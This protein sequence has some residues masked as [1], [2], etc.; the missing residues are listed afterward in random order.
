MAKKIV[1]K[2]L[3]IKNFKGIKDLTIKF[4]PVTNIFGENGSGKTSI[5]DAF[6][7]LLFDKDSEDRTKFEIQPLDSFNNKIHNLET[8]VEGILLLDDHEVTLRKIYKEKW[9]KPKGKAE[10]EL[11]GYETLYYVD[12]I[13][14]KQKEYKEYISSIVDEKLFKL[15]TNPL[16]F[17]SLE[18][19]KRREILLNICGDIEDS[20]VINNDTRLQPIEEYLNKGQKIEEAKQ[21]IKGKTKR[22]KED[23]E[24][25]PSRIDEL[26][27]SIGEEINSND[28]EE[29]KKNIEQE[30]NF[31]DSK[32]VDKSKSSEE[33]LDKKEHY[34]SL[35]NEYNEK[36]AAAKEEQIKNSKVSKIRKNIM[37]IKHEV[38]ICEQSSNN[39]KFKLDML[40]KN[41]KRNNENLA[42]L[43]NEYK[44]IRDK[45]LEI[46]ENNFM[47][48][49]CKRKFEDADIE[50]KKKELE[51]NFNS[52]KANDIKSNKKAGMKLKEETD[53]LIEE[54][55]TIKENIDKDNSKI[56]DK[57]K[58]IEALKKE[59]ELQ[60]E[61]SQEEITFD[62]KEELVNKINA[63]AEEIN[64]FKQED[65]TT[66]KNNKRQLQDELQAINKQLALKEVNAR[67][68]K[69]IEELEE[70]ERDLSIQIAKLEQQEILCQEFIK[71]KVNLLE[72]KVNKMF[73]YVKFRF[74]KEYNSGGIEEDC[75]PIVGGVPFGTNLN[76]AAKINA[77]IDIINT[78]SSHYGVQAPIFIDN[79][80]SVNDLIDSNSQ[81][82]NLVVSQD[83]VLR[84]E[85]GD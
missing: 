34:F 48:P 69:R 77:G 9:V 55:K 79:R 50:Q 25:I 45:R 27:N 83:K 20:E 5:F 30:I 4:S 85:Q 19:K 54:T 12:D 8:E 42:I 43:R 40:E 46:D 60:K 3:S 44:D 22:L 62:G 17:A 21:A 31:I 41:I 80:E 49:T 64:N 74:V 75:E 11:R 65:T 72:D 56:E 2:N 58:E 6:N 37:E 76:T 13:P 10:Q 7:F 63:L 66:L 52:Q 71:S 36:L 26:V 33:L 1:L 61:T 81:I 15:V 39:H 24:Q 18:W 47:C 28:F 14:K 78:L 32:I 70:K 38:E 53:K 68:K 23:R 82:V 57:K 67:T 73:K 59:L 29:K 84:V 16:Y 51:E 35:K